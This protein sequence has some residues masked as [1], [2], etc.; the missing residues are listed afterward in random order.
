MRNNEINKK[1]PVYLHKCFSP[2]YANSLFYICVCIYVYIYNMCVCVCMNSHSNN[3]ATIL[4]VL[5]SAL[6]SYTVLS[7]KL[8]LGNDSASSR[9][10]MHS[11]HERVNAAIRKGDNFPP[12][13]AYWKQKFAFPEQ[14][15]E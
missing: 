1:I 3:I 10:K 7:T 8:L 6:R 9:E 12:F 5:S 14:K 4:P 13:S 11:L 2:K 15:A